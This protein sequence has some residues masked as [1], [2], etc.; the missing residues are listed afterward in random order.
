MSNTPITVTYDGDC[1]LCKASITW[2]SK[3]LTFNALPFQTSDLTPFGLTKEQCSKSVFAISSDNTYSGAKA[4]AFL[5]HNRGNRVLSLLIKLSGPLG[6][7]SYKWVAT[8]RHT[9]FIKLITKI[10]NWMN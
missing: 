3:K 6:Q 7:R 10:L 4:V 5:L 8:H 2:L 9:K 1:E